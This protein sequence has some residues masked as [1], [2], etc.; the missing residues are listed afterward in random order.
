MTLR[1][2]FAIVGGALALASVLGAATWIALPLPARFT[3]GTSGAGV[4]I[5]DR[6]GIP[7]RTTRGAGGAREQWVPYAELD[8]DLINAF[9]AVED[10]R[11]WQHH[12]VDPRAALR[13]AAG[14]LRARRVVSGSSTLTMQL[15]RLLTDAPRRWSGKLVQTA[16]ALRLEAH[17]SKQQ[18]LEQYLNRVELGQGTIGVGAASA[19]YFDASASELSVGQAATLAGIAHAPSRDNPYVSAARARTRRAYALRRMHALGYATKEDVARA[20]GEPVHAVA[21]RSPSL[22]PHFTT[23]VLAWADA[24]SVHPIA[25]GILRTTLSADLQDAVEGEVRHT[26]TMLR[27][28]AVEHAAAVVLDNRTGDVLAWVG[29]PDFWSPNDGQTDMV[30]SP[31]QPGS[32]LKPFLYAMALDRGYTAASVLPDVPASFA[33]PTGA[34]A[35]RNYD[36]RFRGPVRAREALA[37]SYNV[38]AVSIVSRLGTGQLLQTLRLAGFTSLDR[39]A[40]YYGLGLALGDGDVTLIEL[41]NGYRALANG[42]E[43]R[44]WRWRATPRATRGG[45]VSRRVVSP[46]AAAIVLDMLNDADARIPAFGLETPF[47]FPF[48]V[49]VK[50]GTSRHFTDNWAV[51]TTAEFTVAVWAGNFSGRPMQGVSGVTG[52]GP[53][54]HR[55]VM[56]TAKRFPPGALVTP[57]EAGAV[58]VPVCRL[59]GRRATAT[60][61]RLTEWFAPGTAPADSDRWEHDG[62]VTLPEE[63]AA[64]ARQQGAQY[65]TEMFAGEPRTMP[66]A[67][68]AEQ[69]G[70]MASLLQPHSTATS[71]SARASFRITSPMNGDRYAIPSGVE[72]RYASIALR[73]AGPGAQRVRW[74]IDGREYD[75]ARWPLEP[76]THHFRA[77]SA[78]GERAEARVEVFP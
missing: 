41:A 62:V 10:R 29:S 73:A 63:Y 32:S 11:F 59:S 13:A 30:V 4:T 22:A 56:E 46:V 9:V 6:D 55:V 75:D 34:Y 8:A 77:T 35:P 61:A 28:R 58:A 45:A 25:G 24:E 60:C 18:I 39:D 47:D 1:R 53:L 40:E 15:A 23:R 68:H 43:W 64:W 57:A 33:T 72:R 52:A 7:L 16:W 20:S 44:D 74:F 38:P 31:R 66:L 78:R 51:A 14:N 49:A 69:A 17:L 70:Y 3:A 76:G 19:L 37:S 26:V 48:P 5:V 21:T 27:D 2:R 12:G 67:S 65:Q 71:D 54:L 42:G 50:T 36:R